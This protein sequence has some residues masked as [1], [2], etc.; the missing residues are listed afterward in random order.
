[1]HPTL[2]LS[3][4]DTKIGRLF[5]AGI[6]GPQVDHD[7]DALIRDYCLGGVILFSRNIEDPLQLAAL[8]NDLQEK[9]MQ[10]HGIPLFLAVD[11]EGGRVARLQEPFTRFEGNTAIGEDT[12]SVERAREFARVTAREMKLVGLN[13][14]L[15]P[16]V[17]VRR[18]EP[19]KHLAGRTF[20]DNPEKVALLGQIVVKE[21]Q[22]NGVMAVAKH[23]P[24]LGKASL[25]PHH[26]LP[27]IEMESQEMEGINL[28]PF[29]SAIAAGVSGVMTSHAIYPHLAPDIPATLSHKILT[30]LLREDLGF[31]GL[32]ITDDLEMG[33]ID[34]KWGVPQGAVASF[35]A[36]ADILLICKNQSNVLESI[37]ALRKMLISGEIRFQRFQESLERIGETKSRFL[38]RRKKTSL[39]KIKKFFESRKTTS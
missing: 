21:L 13:M 30:S 14:D 19:E 37:W 3:E 7:T 10:Y 12:N 28:P 27:T 1:V 18:G 6:P 32:I 26:H 34:K 9:A 25:D 17:D 24:G 4:I 29:K 36:G 8:C 31:Q 11:Q 2:D 23:F 33:A 35:Q 15:A 39:S 20:S 16:V 22:K 5:M 38:A